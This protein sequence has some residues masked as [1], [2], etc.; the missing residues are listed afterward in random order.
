MLKRMIAI[1]AVLL[2]MA[3][4]TAC[5]KTILDTVE[6]PAL[7]NGADADQIEA[8]IVSHINEYRASEGTCA[9]EKMEGC[10][11]YSRYRS[12]QMA[13]NGCAD[14]DIGDALQA[15]E[16][17]KYGEWTDYRTGE[18][19]Y[20][21]RGFESVT[22]VAKEGTVDEIAEALAANLYNQ[23]YDWDCLGSEKYKLFPLALQKRTGNGT[24][25]QLS[26]WSTSMKILREFK[27]PL[28]SENQQN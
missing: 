7:A 19:Y 5:G 9:A 18:L 22:E 8:L 26:H 4:V 27:N 16:A 23:K 21:V 11:A 1:F 6:Q 20:L 10:D 17:V 14:H 13:E 24:A 12:K 28:K 15:A 25:A 2:I 3:N